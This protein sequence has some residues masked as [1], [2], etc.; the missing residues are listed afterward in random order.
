MTLNNAVRAPMA[1]FKN[2]LDLSATCGG[3]AKLF[4]LIF[5][6]FLS[7]ASAALGEKSYVSSKY[8]KGHVVVIGEKDM[9]TLY[10]D[11]KD[12]KGVQKAAGNL[13]RDIERVT[14]KK[15]ELVHSRAALGKYAIIVG[16]IGHSELIDQLIESGK[17][18]PEAIANQW[19]AYHIQ[20]VYKPFPGVI[21][22][23]VIAGSNKRGASYGVYDLSEKIGVSPWYWWADVPTKKRDR[24]YIIKNTFIQDA[25]KIKYRGIFLNDEAPALTGWTLQNYGNYNH[26]FYEN[27]FELLLRLKANFLWPAMWNNSFNVDDK[28]NMIMADEYGI[29]MSTSHHEPMMRAHKEWTHGGEGPW[30]YANNQKTLYEFWEGGIQRN[31]PYESV[32]TLGM[33]GDGDEPMSESEN[34]SLLEKIVKDQ[35][36]IIAR[37]HEKPLNEVPQ[38]WALYKEVQ[39]YY[40]KGMRVP[41]DVTLLWCDDNWGNIRRLPTPEE[42]KRSGGAGVYY[43]FDY[44][45]G[46]RSYRWINTVPVAKIWEQMNLAYHY[47]ANKIWIVNV[48][49]LKPMEYPIEFFLRMAWNPEA[50]PKERI[51]EYGKLW[52][53][54]EFGASY[55]DEIADLM[56]GYTRHNSRR[57][58][59]LQ[60]AF[61]YSQ[62]HYD[63][64]DRITAEVKDLTARA[65][66]LYEKMP[67]T[68]KDAFFQL[69]LHPV[70]AS[71]IITEMY[72]MVAKNQLYASQGRANANDYA[73]RARLL[74]EMDAALE[75]QFHTELSN[76]KWNHFMSQP[77]IGYT[78]WNNPPAN[79]LPLLYHYEPHGA[80]DMGVAVEGMKE[81]WPVPAS[82]Q[83]PSFHPY[84]KAQRNIEIFNKGT[85]AFNFL[86]KASEP[87]IILSNTSGQVKVNQ[88][89]QVSIDWDQ[90]PTGKASGNI[91]IAGTGWGGATI[92]VNIVKPDARVVEN[93]QGFIEADGYVAIEAEN[94]SRKKDSH[95]FAWEKIP[96]HGRTLSSMSSFPVTDF[97]FENPKKA[98]YLEYDIHFF[99]TG[100]FTVEAI[101][102]PSWPIFPGRG[103]RYG[104]GFGNETPHIVDIVKDMSESAW[105]ES[106]RIDARKI[107]S[108][109]K[110]NKPGMHKLRIYMVD[111]AVTLQK[112]VI[113]TGGLMPSYLGPQQS[114][115][116]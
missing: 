66:A 17:I 96:Q 71:A 94:Y 87:W 60:E 95:G 104:I 34:V 90:A 86:A 72:D 32:I 110:I 20:T 18:D 109:H 33:R 62:L 76:G 103:L 102:A 48:G 61:I 43:H 2:P 97:S 23:L 63:E 64:A 53:K 9:A 98:P 83:L 70:K 114:T 80:A 5:L 52:A 42:R 81:A 108:K 79:T 11:N 26:Q 35:R 105:E 12:F 40:E 8:K 29:V 16:A 58:P 59:E 106:V 113:N 107:S 99:S 47:D 24:L 46:P 27:V 88:P 22:A 30:D 19:D 116:Y 100:E 38:V 89:I 75:K 78:H 111:P 15:P 85:H 56:T 115:K 51:E 55:V 14:G 25:P 93:L 57:K 84:G 49:D 68:H 54:R 69:V 50:W 65:E 67:A 31:K 6:F 91:H 112:I 39:G 74:F 73:E 4:C 21:R 3:M 37:V 10:V 101:F 45:G 82:Y 77:H 41:D 13:Q 28:Q 1:Q 44:V 36:E 7:S 92:K